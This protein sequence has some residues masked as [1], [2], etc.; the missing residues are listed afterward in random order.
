MKIDFKTQTARITKFHIGYNNINLSLGNF[1]VGLETRKWGEKQEGT[2][3]I[4]FKIDGI[5]YSIPLE[6]F[7]NKVKNLIKKLDKEN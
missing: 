4:T 3:K 1:E 2:H 5:N 6:I 7:Q